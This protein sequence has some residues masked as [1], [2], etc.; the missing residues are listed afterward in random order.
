MKDFSQQRP[1]SLP[2]GLWASIALLSLYL[3]LSLIY[4]SLSRFPVF[5]VPQLTFGQQTYQRPA[6]PG[7]GEERQRQLLREIHSVGWLAG[8]V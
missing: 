4:L 6:R 2:A 7:R 8:W 5:L 1:L 3:S